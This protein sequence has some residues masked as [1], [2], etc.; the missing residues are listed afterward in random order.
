M[1]SRG[2][3]FY[4]TMGI[5]FS[6]CAKHI[7][8]LYSANKE[9]NNTLILK[10]SA[11]VQGTNVT[12]N[13]RLMVENKFVKKVTVKGIPDGENTYHFTSNSGM[14]KEKI[15][16]TETINLMDGEEKT[17]LLDIPPLSSSYWT[18]L[19]VSSLVSAVIIAVL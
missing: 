19:I 7:E 13:D 12:V 5:I 3:L 9:N 16:F 2:L 8:V 14:Y 1:K 11:N 4:I 15:N 6:S 10:P 18:Y 17:K